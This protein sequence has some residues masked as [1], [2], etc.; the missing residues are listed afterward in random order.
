[1][2]GDP[3]RNGVGPQHI[4]SASLRRRRNLSSPRKRT[5]VPREEDDIFSTP[6]PQA[7]RE[8]PPPRAR[9][10]EPPRLVEGPFRSAYTNASGASQFIPR[11]RRASGTDEEEEADGENED[12]PPRRG[13]WK[14][15]IFSEGLMKRNL[16]PAQ[17]HKQSTGE[18]QQQ[19]LSNTPYAPADESRPIAKV[20]SAAE[21]AIPDENAPGFAPSMSQTKVVPMRVA[22]VGGSVVVQT[23]KGAC[24]PPQSNATPS[25]SQDQ[26]LPNPER[27]P[28]HGFVQAKRQAPAT[29][30]NRLLFPAVSAH[31]LPPPVPGPPSKRASL[32]QN[33]NSVAHSVDDPF[34]A[35]LAKRKTR[36]QTLAGEREISRVNTRREKLVRRASVQHIDLRALYSSRSVGSSLIGS[37]TSLG[38][39]N[40][41]GVKTKRPRRPPS[42]STPPNLSESNKELVLALGLEAVY[43]R[44]AENHR[45]HIDVVREVAARQPSLEDADRV[46]RN[47]REAA[48]REYARLLRRGEVTYSTAEN[49]TEE[50]EK[51]DEV[52]DVSG[53]EDD[54]QPV[55]NFQ[56][57]VDSNLSPTSLIP[58]RR[59]RL[60]GLKI[61]PESPDSSPTWPPHYSPPTPTRAHEFRRLERQGRGE[62]AK[63]REAR[64]VRR[65]HRPNSADASAE[66]D[67]QRIVAYLLQLQ[68]DDTGG[69]PSEKPRDVNEPHRSREQI[70]EP[71][72]HEDEGPSIP[73]GLERH[74]DVDAIPF[75]GN[76]FAEEQVDAGE[77]IAANERQTH[78]NLSAEGSRC[79]GPPGLDREC[80]A[81]APSSPACSA[82]AALP[83]LDAE[84][85]NSDDELL[86]DGDLVA[87]EELVRRKGLS[88]VKFRTAHLYGLLLDS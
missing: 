77:V 39:N 88:S 68:E 21:P 75:Q 10:R 9:G 58:Q 37:A 14:S 31:D 24:G 40:S 65:S 17:E 15:P 61:S 63:L 2:S 87:H 41:S 44:M 54:N 5:I 26:V 60:L 49:E 22:Q 20:V 28:S 80:A 69:D 18:A 72:M 7:V 27:R 57:P 12:W 23:S 19:C 45:F 59:G 71:E 11:G 30:R 66:D 16:T 74:A 64:R 29:N 36:R 42:S 73:P 53:D 47:M 79:N 48:G 51:E 8:S 82:V 67:E 81:Q 33:P 1:M 62:E 6:P 43:S 83:L 32:N 38:H 86:L 56:G 76:G 35:P 78:E 50:S 52:A 84:W 4:P 85:T 46:L 70:I 13:K 55:R 34:T 25:P 3:T